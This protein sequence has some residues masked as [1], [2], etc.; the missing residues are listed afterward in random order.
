MLASEDESRALA[1]LK[2]S[3]ASEIV[4]LIVLTTDEMFL[5]TL[6]EGVGPS[7]RL[8]HVLS[9][10]KVSDL[11][12]A[13]GVGILVLD[14]Q[15]LHEAAARFIADI[16]RQFPDLVVVV[17]G[18]REAENELGRLISDG[19]IYRFIHKP[20]SPARARLFAEAAVKRFD[21][22]RR[23]VIPVTVPAIP[24]PAR[25]RLAI[26]AVCAAL[27]L[28]PLA[29]WWLAHR[30]DSERAA[31]SAPASL[32]VV[33]EA[34]APAAPAVRG[35]LAQAQERLLTRA[36]NALQ[37]QRLEEAAAA[38]E[39]ARKAGIDTERV[40]YLATQLAKARERSKAPPAPATTP[41]ATTPAATTPAAP[42]VS[43]SKDL[44]AD[45]DAALAMERI[46]GGQLIEP[47]DDN[48]RFYVEQAIKE[49]PQGE[50][51][52]R[53]AKALS[54]ALLAAARESIERRDFSRAS[55]LIE[56]AGSIAAPASVEEMRRSLAAARQ[57]GEL[58]KS[59]QQSLAEDRLV[60][61]A[62][63][64]A[65]YY[66]AALRKLDP[67][68]PALA[69]LTDDLGAR[70][71]AKARASL[72][73]RQYDAAR[74]WLDAAAGIEYAS[75]QAQTLRHDLDGALASSS[76]AAEVVNA[77]ELALVKSVRPVYPAKAESGAL[78]GWVELDFTVDETGAVRD[79]SVHAASPKGIF[80][81]AATTALSQW[82]Y[83]PVTVDSKPV[84]R[85][86]RIR[87]RF[88]LPR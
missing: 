23:R 54:I 63:D 36:Q 18:N 44:A 71:V 17:A 79:V 27:G 85:R 59:A 74:A 70:L 20:M 26:G 2:F 51:A 43:T 80:D 61:P 73:A 68:N 82:R 38:I 58:L 6:R 67:Q 24:Q 8:W 81:Q 46:K 60:E 13:G 22:Q 4:E 49:S 56:T 33:P 1:A 25:R 69:T 12:V 5:Q 37:Q 75:P 76:S 86:A 77:S 65:E 29:S 83:R 10:D 39:A 28:L 11:L 21:E 34:P 57:Q 16:K 55:S 64:S 40:A 3:L 9:S 47:E 14:V 52:R 15:A 30:G 66:V 78:E 41:A 32:P 72:T 50:A 7:R 87:M 35:V 48:A 84:P 31:P 42:S 19:S 62:N 45:R 88:E 53:A